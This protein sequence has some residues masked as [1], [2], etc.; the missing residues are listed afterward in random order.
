MSFVATWADPTA[1]V[2]C[3]K[4]CFLCKLSL[5]YPNRRTGSQ[6]SAHGALKYDTLFCPLR[7]G[8]HTIVLLA[9]VSSPRTFRAQE[10]GM[11]PSK[12]PAW[13]VHASAPS[14]TR[15]SQDED[16]SA[17]ASC[18][19]KSPSRSTVCWS[20][21]SGIGLRVGHLHGPGRQVSV[22]EREQDDW[23]ETIIRRHRRHRSKP[24]LVSRGTGSYDRAA[25]STG[26]DE[27]RVCEPKPSL[28]RTAVLSRRQIREHELTY[29]DV[30]P[31]SDQVLQRPQRRGTRTA[32]TTLVLRDEGFS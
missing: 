32:R 5:A 24:Y 23:R 8:L 26:L 3:R 30:V 18:R 12:Q 17:S 21:M 13:L 14:S 2:T 27:E 4:Y 16:A 10:P 28:D 1:S 22:H 6:L 7:A 20:T 9:A 25:N 15:S 29:A 19:S 31:P 11:W